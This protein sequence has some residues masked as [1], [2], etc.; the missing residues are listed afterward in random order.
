[1]AKSDLYKVGNRQSLRRLPTGMEITR[2]TK[3]EPIDFGELDSPEL[4]RL[5]DA[6]NGS[7]F[8]ASWPLERVT[9]WLKEQI[10]R[11]N[12]TFPP[13]ARQRIHVRLNEPVGY[14]HGRIVST[15]TILVSGRWVH[16]YPDKDQP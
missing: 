3:H 6:V 4:K 5:T 14:V 11:Q 7:K 13:G 8:L 9:D 15:I 10:G 12:W 1:M 2:A 16:C